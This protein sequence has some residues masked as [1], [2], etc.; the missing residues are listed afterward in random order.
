MQSRFDTAAAR[1]F[2]R[3]LTDQSN[4]MSTRTSFLSASL[5]EL[6]ASW[7]DRRY[8]SFARVCEE[9]T[10]NL[11]RFAEHA[12][13]YARYLAKKANAYDNYLTR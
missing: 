13:Q 1:H 11:K 7:Q 2:A 4:E 10:E 8:D 3:L 5:L 12:D 9:A 6:K